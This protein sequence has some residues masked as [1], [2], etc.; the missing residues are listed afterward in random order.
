[1]PPKIPMAVAVCS[2][3]AL[4]AYAI[5]EKLSV[6]LHGDQLFVSA[7]KVDLIRGPVL[8]RL[9]DG[10][11]VAFDF[12]LALWAGS[13]SSVRRRSFERFVVSYDLWEEKYAVTNLRKPA[14]SASG[15]TDNA[16]GKWCLEHISIASPNVGASEPVWVG[17][18]IRT[19]DT[20]QD[21]ELFSA[22]GISLIGLVDLLSRPARPGEMR[23]SLETGPLML[24]EV[25]R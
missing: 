13:R 21:T 12:H 16:I 18:E 3:L 24:H 23:W 9:K 17:L 5:T 11:T 1:M 2:G 25:R 4:A 14:A 15:L 7:P 19:A 22:G 6:E 8:T 10:G 20:R